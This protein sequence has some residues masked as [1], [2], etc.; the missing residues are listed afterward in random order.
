[1]L[2]FAQRP[3]VIWAIDFVYRFLSKEADAWFR[4]IVAENR[5][6]REN[7]EMPVED[8]MQMLLNLSKKMGNSILFYYLNST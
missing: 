5:K 4:N 3:M 1:M 6:A 8:V 7:V 2:K